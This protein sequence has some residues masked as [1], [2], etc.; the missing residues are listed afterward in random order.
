[1]IGLLFPRRARN[2][3]LARSAEC[4]VASNRRSSTWWRIKRWD[5]LINFG[6]TSRPE[7]D[8]PIVV[9]DIHL[10]KLAVNK[11]KTFRALKTAN[12]QTPEW[13]TE[14]DK[15]LLWHQ[16]G[17]T[18][19]CRSL[20]QSFQGRGII[21][22]FPHSDFEFPVVPLY[23]KYMPKGREFRVHV[24]GNDVISYAQ[25]KKKKNNNNE[26]LAAYSDYIRTYGTGWVYCV[27]DIRHIDSVYQ[28]GIDTVAALGLDFG[29]VDVYYWHD[30]PHVLE[31]NTAPGITA[32]TT[33]SAYAEKIKSL[34]D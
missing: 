21:V 27:R 33:L 32:A 17:S 13:T 10:V 31:V 26:E 11:I 24:W 23:T 9:N 5:I 1:M 25:K 7:I 34:V 14:R 6:C 12:I 30:Q 2:N 20:V 29:A 19:M 18:V 28:I 22:S 8:V 4:D 15:A 16:T 3:A